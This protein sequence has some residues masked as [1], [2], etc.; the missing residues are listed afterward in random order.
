MTVDVR[1][2]PA[3]DASATRPTPATVTPPAA[4]SAR[5]VPRRIGA[6]RATDV[7]QVAGAALSAVALTTIL[8]AYLLP[9][10]GALGFVLCSYALFLGLYALLVSM[11][12]DRTTVVDRVMST[13]VRTAA[14]VLVCA[15]VYVVGY[16]FVSGLRALSHWNLV[17]QDMT[18]AGPLD[19]LDVGGVAHAVVG[20]LIMI[21]IA[22]L[23]V[24]PLGL[25]CAIFLTEVPGR[26][27]R[28]VRTVVEAMTALPS[29]IA[30]LFVYLTW[31]LILGFD[32][33]GLAAGLAI[34][35][36]MLPIIIRSAD[37]VLRLVPGNL[38][39]ASYA[40][41]ASHLRTVRRVVLPTARSGLT[42]AVI[43]GTAR[44]IGETSPVLLTAGFTAAMNVNPVDGPMVSLPL[45]AFQYIKMPEQSYKDRGFAAAALLLV[46]VMVLFVIARIVGGRAPGQL[47]RIQRR[48]RARRSARDKERIAGPLP[49]LAASS[50]IAQLPPDDASP[51]TGRL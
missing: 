27:S 31:I 42:T 30:G 36:M 13:L 14:I 39:E 49:A 38:K 34:S 3:A 29:I 32:K 5:P 40:L 33:S 4:P 50:P 47:S 7:Y 9:F 19:P 51:R 22:L 45:V 23:V 20:T 44:G 2:E 41:G 37:V 11:D 18:D 24:I 16:V 15:L 28:V 35:L 6:V 17:T 43:L 1:D 48:S 8:F 21:T 25:V 10:D 26:F 12:E 46:L